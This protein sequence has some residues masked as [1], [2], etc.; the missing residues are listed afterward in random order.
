MILTTSLALGLGAS[1]NI[2]AQSV[3]RQA[4]IDSSATTQAATTN[5]ELPQLQEQTF[6]LVTP[7][8]YQVLDKLLPDHPNRKKV[9]YV[10]KGFQHGFSL[11]YNGPL[12]N[13]QPKNLLSA[14]QHADKLWSSLM[15]EVKLGGMLG[16]FP[17]QPLDP[18]ICSPVGMVEK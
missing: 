11:K 13:R 6:K 7:I 14:Y 18:L 10:V 3:T 12:E 2:N 17:V 4:I 8:K 5:P 9:D 16:P 1:S 15:K